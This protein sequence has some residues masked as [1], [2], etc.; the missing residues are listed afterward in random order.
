MRQVLVFAGIVSALLFFTGCGSQ[1]MH[2]ATIQPSVCQV[3]HVDASGAV[4]KVAVNPFEIADPV[5]TH[6]IIGE[7][8][9]GFLNNSTDI[10]C[11]Q[12]MGVVLTD[13]LREAVRSAGLSLTDPEHADY[14]LAGTVER[15]WV[16]EHA[17]GHYPEYSKAYVKFDVLLLGADGTEKWGHSVDIFK[18][19]PDCFEATAQNIPTLSAAIGDGV[20]EILSNRG[21]WEAMD[22]RVS[23]NTP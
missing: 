8:K 14:V 5:L 13:T 17:T 19:S 21:F 10:I 7:A 23:T 15:I 6:G 20:A 9:T 12:P 11:E 16:E 4:V 2:V 22:V 3:V 1:T 18:V